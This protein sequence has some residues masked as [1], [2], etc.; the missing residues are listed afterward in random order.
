M[1]P[2]CISIRLIGDLLLLLGSA[3]GLAALGTFDVRVGSVCVKRAVSDM[4]VKCLAMRL[5]LASETVFRRDS[6]VGSSVLLH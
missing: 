4:S 5:T 2:F 3:R 6:L 1:F